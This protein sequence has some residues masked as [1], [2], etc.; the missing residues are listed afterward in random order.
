MDRKWY[1]MHWIEIKWL[2]TTLLEKGDKESEIKKVR[3][4][5]DELL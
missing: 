1:G 3:E 4:T 5:A 2:L